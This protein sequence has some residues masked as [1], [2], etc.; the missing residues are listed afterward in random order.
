MRIFISIPF[1][2]TEILENTITELKGQLSKDKISW[3]KPGQ[4]HCTLQFIGDCDEKRIPEVKDIIKKS[5]AGIAPYHVVVK[6]LGIF[7][8]Q[9]HPRVV[10]AD[11]VDN[12]ETE[13]LFKNVSRMLQSAR[14]AEPESRFHPHLTLARVKEMKAPGK[15][16]DI[17]KSKKDVVF[18]EF[19]AVEIHLKESRL[20]PGGAEYK[21]L[22]T[23]G[24]V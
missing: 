24:L 4:I 6:S 7:G 19:I 15:L 8:E 1:S 18:S 5:A 21:L 20:T 13:K 16:Y 2:V 17:V 23:V 9:N 22:H 12:G 11:W 14:I 10:W 3:V